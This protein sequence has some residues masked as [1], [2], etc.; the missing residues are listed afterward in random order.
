[1][2]IFAH[3]LCFQA[4]VHQCASLP[5]VPFMALYIVQLFVVETSWDKI[6]FLGK[7]LFKTDW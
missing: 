1:M 5:G 3:F 4:N 6:P 7:I 2:E